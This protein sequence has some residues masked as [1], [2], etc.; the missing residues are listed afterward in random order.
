MP[1][2]K[3]SKKNLPNSTLKDLKSQKCGLRHTV[4]SVSGNKY[5]GEWR[6]DKKHGKGTQVW[7]RPAAVYNG[8][9][10]FGKPDGYGDYS[11]LLPGSQ[12][13]TRRYSGGWKN[14]KKHGD[15]M[16]FYNNLAF[17]EGEWSE[18][19][20]SGWGR[21]Y[22]DNGDIYEGEWMKDKR[23]GQGIIR[24]SNGNWYEG[25]WQHGQKNGNGK[26]YYSDK[27][28]LY[29]GFWVD[30]VA[31]CGTL[32]D[33]ERDAAPTPAKLP[34]PKVCLVDVES[35]LREAESAYNGQS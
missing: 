2:I 16:Y 23:D 25:T 11:V 10:K 8:E 15:G 33:Y 30:G 32:S 26:F 28:M 34:I 9:W 31:K 7:K 5:T 24:F 35:V 18:N 4:F 27:G 22:Y 13:Y 19:Q 20:R 6:D 21:M 29:E 14:G 1:V 17:Y 3:R 12:E